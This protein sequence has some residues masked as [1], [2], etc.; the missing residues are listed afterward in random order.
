MATIALQ[1]IGD[2]LDDV[3]FTAA[4][5]GGDEVPGGS[6]LGGWSLPVL[7]LVAN[8]D[9]ASHDVTV[10]NLSAVTVPAG[11]TAAIQVNAGVSHGTLV[12]VTY[13]SA[14]SVTVAALDLA[15]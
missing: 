2:G 13:S 1:R 6:E 12:S 5:G 4:S 3:T 15:R 7:L 9:A 11:A 10:G 14:T 8:G